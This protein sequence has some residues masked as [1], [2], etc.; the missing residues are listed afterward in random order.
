MLTVER[1]NRGIALE[2]LKGIRERVSANR[3]QRAR[4]GNWGFAQMRTFISYKAKR[5]GVPVLFVD[6]RNT[7]IECAKCGYV[8]KKNRPDQ[9]TFSCLYCHHTDNA[10]HNAAV[11]IRSRALAA[12]GYVM[13]PEVLAA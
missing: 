8:N 9:A 4:L 5:A 1:T 2:D 13:K 10:D 12:R 7:S 6:P 3:S 11:N